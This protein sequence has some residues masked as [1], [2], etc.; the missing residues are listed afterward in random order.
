VY[1]RRIQAAKGWGET[2]LH[3]GLDAQSTAQMGARPSERSAG[4][5]AYRHGARPRTL[6]TRVGPLVLHVPQGRDG[7]GSPPRFARYPR[8]EQA[9]VLALMERV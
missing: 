6:P 7:R 3:Q 5:Q 1:S 8:S 4:R 9:L 2:G